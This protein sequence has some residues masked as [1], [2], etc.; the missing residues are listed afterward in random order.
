VT[1]WSDA[2][3]GDSPARNSHDE[4]R[5]N[6]Q[7]RTARTA[8]ATSVSSGVFRVH[9]GAS[10]RVEDGGD[11]EVTDGGDI[12]IR[13]GSLIME[14]EDGTEGLVYFGPNVGG[15]RT[16]AFAFDDG[17]TAILLAGSPGSTYWRFNDRA[18]HEIL[19]NDGL[20]GVGLARPHLNYRLVPSSDAQITGTSF[21]PSHTS[22]SFV[23]LWTGINPVF[24]PRV[25]IGITPNTAGGGTAH[26]R[27]LIGGTDVSG[28]LTAGGVHHFNIPNWGTAINP[29]DTPSFEVQGYI[30]G[31]G[32]RVLLQ[33][34]RFHAN[35][36]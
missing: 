7:T 20:T 22:T 24:H 13:G 36:S 17:A 26:W 1:V 16:W 19:S 34:D 15:R 31:G 23:T 5:R 28:D 35:Q 21:V 8:Q 10:F 30:A 32:T 25:T 12:I 2:T 3:A 14:N 11:V 9:S 18:G 33:V 27:L 29:G 6:Q 4:V